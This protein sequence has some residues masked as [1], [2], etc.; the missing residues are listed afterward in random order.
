MSNLASSYDL[1]GWHADACKMLDERL[2]LVKS[3]LGIANPVTLRSMQ[4]LA[5]MYCKAGD[6]AKAESLYHQLWD[7][8]RKALGPE[9]SIAIDLENRLGCCLDRMAR[10]DD[11]EKHYLNSY[12]DLQKAKDVPWHWFPAYCD[13]L[14]GLYTRWEK[15]QEA[16]NWRERTIPYYERALE[17]LKAQLR[18]DASST[19]R[20]MSHN[21]ANNYVSLGRYADAIKLHEETLVLWKTKFGIEEPFGFDATKNSLAWLLV[22]APDAKLRDPARAVALAARAVEL[23][24]NNVDYPCTLGTA[25]YRAGQWKEAIADLEK[26]IPRRDQFGASNANNGFF[27]AMAYWQLGEKDKA[28]EW[29]AKAVNRMEQG[30]NNGSETRRLHA[31][32]AELLHI[33]KKD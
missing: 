19:Y 9:S 2:G 5:E 27:L 26:V 32:A 7:A 8:Q 12:R 15:P 20:T 31:E 17:N 3:N 10:F 1:L 13:R 25:R 21:L 22:T 11:A 6:P 24:P 33:Q 16:I 30:K 29:F 28:R 18:P 14:A 23:S 4:D